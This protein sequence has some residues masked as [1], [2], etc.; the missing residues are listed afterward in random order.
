[1]AKRKRTNNN[2]QNITH[3]T[4]DLVIGLT[5]YDVCDFFNI[6][7]MTNIL[8]IEISKFYQLNIIPVLD[9]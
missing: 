8:F 7:V 4:K 3:K 1:M 6:R 9:I 5:P 2:L